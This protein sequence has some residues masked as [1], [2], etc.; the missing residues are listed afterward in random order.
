[1]QLT[2]IYLVIAVSALL[3]EALILWRGHRASLLRHYPFFYCYVS[4]VFVRNFAIF[5]LAQRG[6]EN[7]AEIYWHSQAAV[8]LLRFCVL[9]EVFRAVYATLGGVRELASRTL[10]PL[11]GCFAIMLWISSPTVPPHESYFTTFERT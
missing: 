6:V 4:G 2:P 5:I 9:W 11:L 1:M 3:F 7:Y 8:S 10:L